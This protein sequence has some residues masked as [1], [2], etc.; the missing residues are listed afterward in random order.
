V[1]SDLDYGNARLRAMRA[2]M[3]RA[4]T[5]ERMLEMRLDEVVATLAG[6]DYGA[7]LHGES[8]RRSGL[9]LVLGALRHNLARTFAK[10]RRSYSGD[11]ARSLDLV[12]SRW[13][14]ANLITLVRGHARRAMPE[15]VQELMLPAAS[16]DEATLAALTRLPSLRQ[17]LEQLVAWSIPSTRGAR[18]LFAAWPDYERSGEVGILEHRIRWVYATEAQTARDEGW[19]APEAGEILALAT[20]RD[21]LMIA[22]RLWEARASGEPGLLMRWALLPGGTVDKDTLA[23]AE[24]KSSRSE[25][26]ATLL[27]GGKLRWAAEALSLWSR[28]GNPAEL[29]RRLDARVVERALRGFGRGDPLSLAVPVAFVHARDNEVRNLRLVAEV[30][31]GRLGADAVRRRWLLR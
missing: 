8:L 11:A 27:S 2:R 14:A 29:E 9:G 5:L 12:L 26:V 24:A 16:L 15:D 20:D 19:L 25:V 17:A 6:S 3:I 21:N 30:A 22:L 4:E 13:D 7:D 28:E 31:A 10:V 23:R 18:L 1:T